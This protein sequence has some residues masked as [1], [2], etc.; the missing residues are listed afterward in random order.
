M[1]PSRCRLCPT[2]LETN[3]LV[4]PTGITRK[5]QDNFPIFQVVFHKHLHEFMQCTLDMLA[6]IFVVFQCCNF[7]RS[8][9]GAPFRKSTRPP[10][11]GRYCKPI[12][13]RDSETDVMRMRHAYCTRKIINM[14]WMQLRKHLLIFWHPWCPENCADSGAISRLRRNFAGLPFLIF[15]P[16]RFL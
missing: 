5:R 11:F 8:N 14:C 9:K 13:R 16:E 2:N 3:P 4:V 6:F 7:L 15:F 10:L 1:W 12:P